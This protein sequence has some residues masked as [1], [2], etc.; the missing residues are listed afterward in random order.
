M[1]KALNLVGERFGALTVIG[2][3]PNDSQGKT[4][5]LCK[6]DC[7]NVCTVSRGN[8]KSGQTKSCGCS[9]KYLLKIS[10][11]KHGLRYTSIYHVW[12]SM[13]DRC[14]NPRCHAYENYGGRGI[15]V[16][17][18]WQNDP[19]AFYDWAV[20]HGF[21]KGLSI[22]RID[23]DKGYPPE[24]CRWANT[25][26]QGNNRRSNRCI[27]YLGETHTVKEWSEILKIDYADMKSRLRSGWSI[28][29]IVS[30]P[31]NRHAKRRSPFDGAGYTK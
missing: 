28:E 3:G 22:D 20:S 23:N 9:T 16:C 6:C 7:G 26:T 12:N 11:T 14:N 21:K 30:T 15:K 31:V 1:S 13:K 18:E 17:D 24:N 10:H 25:E 8:L 5:W 29:K 19:K 2:R 4:T 27:N